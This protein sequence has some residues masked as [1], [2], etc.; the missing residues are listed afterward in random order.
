MVAEMLMYG[1]V[2]AFGWWGANHYI[3]E[4]HLE[5]K[6]VL[7]E[8]EKQEQKCTDWE[9]KKNPDGTINRFRTCESLSKT[10]P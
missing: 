8:K 6:P 1:F 5:S 10:S 4:P 9:E 3:I 2:S 7:M